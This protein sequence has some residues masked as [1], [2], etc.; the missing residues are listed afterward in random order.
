VA[1][2]NAAAGSGNW[3][4]VGIER[5]PGSNGVL[6]RSSQPVPRERRDQGE[7]RS[8]GCFESARA[9]MPARNEHVN[10]VHV[11]RRLTLPIATALVLGLLVADTPRTAALAASRAG[12]PSG[13]IAFASDRAGTSNVY[14]ASADG[15]A[16]RQL[17]HTGGYSPAVSPDGARIAFLRDG[18]VY[19]VGA[20]G[21]N[22][23]QVV[24]WGFDPAW[25]PN[26]RSLAFVRAGDI[27]V[28][29]ADGTRERRLTRD[30]RPQDVNTLSGLPSWSPDWSRIVVVTTDPGYAPNP[31]HPGT[32]QVVATF[33]H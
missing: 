15:S 30:A 31:G 29:S 27:Y 32:G 10:V 4:I 28:V 23:R 9:P 13:V 14:L 11:I 20:D 21:R 3:V 18:A 2:G 19:V 12:G 33:Y 26:A 1:Q 25:S 8:F 6:E 16:L 22:E 5:Y 17:T 7:I 24:A